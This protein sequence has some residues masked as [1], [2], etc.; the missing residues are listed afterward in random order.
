M[1]ALIHQPHLFDVARTVVKYCDI[2][3]NSIAPDVAVKKIIYKF[4]QNDNCIGTTVTLN[5]YGFSD[6]KE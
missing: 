1:N 2:E 4:D 5:P 3:G 6:F